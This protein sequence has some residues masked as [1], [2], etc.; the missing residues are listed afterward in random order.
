MSLYRDLP[1]DDRGIRWHWYLGPI[2][3]ESDFPPLNCKHDSLPVKAQTSR[4]FCSP[5]K[6]KI[7]S[8]HQRTQCMRHRFD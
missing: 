8:N 1:S 2:T 3:I 6:M 4:S 7:A 5:E